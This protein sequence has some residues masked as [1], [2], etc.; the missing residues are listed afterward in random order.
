MAD[1]EHRSL[2]ARVAS[3]ETAITHISGDIKRLVQ[4]VESQSERMERRNQTP[5]GVLASWAGV[6]VTGVLLLLAPIYNTTAE[7]KNLIREYAN[8]TVDHQIRDASRDSAYHVR[9]HALEREVFGESM[10]I[11]DTNK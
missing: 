7:T 1:N 6:V 5:W 4:I 11:I 10:Q 2:S 3:L 8:K 9:V